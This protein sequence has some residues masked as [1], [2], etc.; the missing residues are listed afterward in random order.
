VRRRDLVIDLGDGLK[1]DA[2]LTLPIMGEGPFP[3][4]LLI[5]GSGNMDMD[6]YL[7]PIATGTDEPTRPFLQIA[8]Y[9]SNRGFA[10][11]RYNKR[12]VGLNGEILDMDAWGNMTIQDL[13]QDAERALGVL[14]Q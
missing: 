2:Q 7:P 14:K 8:E 13:V 3:G 4:V 5:H 11:L 1:T 10:V 6:E 9:M 12:G